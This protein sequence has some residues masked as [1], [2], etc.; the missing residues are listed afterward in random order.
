[1]HEITVA[2]IALSRLRGIIP[3]FK[4]VTGALDET[5]LAILRYSLASLGFSILGIKREKR[6][7]YLLLSNLTPA[8]PRYRKITRAL[9]KI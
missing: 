2:S 8:D 4:F 1:M 6:A 5:D 3:E 7:V 9:P